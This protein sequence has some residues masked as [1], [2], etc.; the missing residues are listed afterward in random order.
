ME[1][2][3]ADSVDPLLCIYAIACIPTN[4]T[5]SDTLY[6]FP[7]SLDITYIVSFD[8]LNFHIFHDFKV[9]HKSFPTK[10]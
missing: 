2:I 4:N 8:G 10:N 7:G 5:I 6:W 3:S 9:N 1:I